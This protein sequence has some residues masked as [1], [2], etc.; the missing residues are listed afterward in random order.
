[1]PTRLP[2]S[3]S[4][5]HCVL[6]NVSCNTINHACVRVVNHSDYADRPASRGHR[7]VLRSAACPL[8]APPALTGGASSTRWLSMYMSALR[9][10][11]T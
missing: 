11:G 6:W 4:T 2:A 1:L 9:Y 5:S 8:D 3:F 10:D 7:C